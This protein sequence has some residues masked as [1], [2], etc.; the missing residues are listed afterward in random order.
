MLTYLL[1]QA[2]SKVYPMLSRIVMDVCAIPASSVPCEHLFSTGGE[3][4]TDQHSCLGS[5]KFEQ[6]QVLR[7]TW[8]CRIMDQA[9]LNSGNVEIDMEEFQELLQQDVDLVE[10][11]HVDE[12]IL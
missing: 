5:E 4:A 2:N 7:H 8:H 6:L 3:I 9:N 11:Q 10:L 1:V 12:V